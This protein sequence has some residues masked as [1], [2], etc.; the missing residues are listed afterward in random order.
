MIPAT[1]VPPHSIN[2][3]DRIAF[4]KSVREKRKQLQLN[5]HTN[6]KYLTIK[7]IQMFFSFYL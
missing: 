5:L 4:Y 6:G 3:L 1:A 2:T 7:D